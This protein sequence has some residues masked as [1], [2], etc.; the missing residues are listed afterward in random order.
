[1]FKNKE[2]VLAVYKEQS[3][4]KA[5]KKLFVSQPSLSSSIKRIEQKVGSPIFDRSN[6]PITLTEVGEK[7]IEYALSKTDKLSVTYDNLVYTDGM[8]RRLVNELYLKRSK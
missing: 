7:Y 6:S 8:A 3:F 1:M 5:A 2:Y 4:V